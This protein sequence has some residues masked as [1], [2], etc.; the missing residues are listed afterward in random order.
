MPG[1]ERLRVDNIERGAGDPG[2][3]Q[4]RDQRVA[5]D[6]ASRATL[7]GQQPGPIARS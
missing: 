4:R 3:I 5:L 1:R 2:L 7:T 6:E